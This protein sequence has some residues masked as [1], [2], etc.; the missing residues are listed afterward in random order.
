MYRVHGHWFW[1]PIFGQMIGGVIGGLLY[2][3]TIA[4]HHSSAEYQVSDRS[5]VSIR[6]STDKELAASGVATDL[7][8]R[9]VGVANIDCN[10]EN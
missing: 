7:K 2:T 3:L 5:Q 9:P 8:M 10:V 1:Y 6:Y 4:M